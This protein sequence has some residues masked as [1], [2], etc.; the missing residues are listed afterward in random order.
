MRKNKDVKM[1][2]T[3]NSLSLKKPRLMHLELLRLLAIYLVIFNHT[4][5]AGYKLFET[6][7][8]SPL[9]FAYMM[10]SVFCKIAV[11]LF[12]MISGALLLQ[13]EESY[14][15]LFKKRILRMVIVLLVISLPYYFW[16]QRAHGVSI[17]NFFTYIYGNSA[18]TSLWYLYSYIGFLLILPFL[19]KMVKSMQNK[20]FIY[21]FV[22]Y[23]IMVGILP[24]L[25]YCFFDGNIRV[26]EQFQPVLFMSQSVFFGLMGYYFE[27][28]FEPKTSKVK[29]GI[30]GVCAS[31]TVILVTCIITHFKLIVNCAGTVENSELFFNNFIAIPTVTMYYLIKQFAKRITNTKLQ[32]VIT[33]MGSAVFGVYLI[34]KFIR[35]FTYGIYAFSFPIVGSFMA[36]LLW[37]AAVWVI[38]LVIVIIVKNI[39]II[40]KV[41]NKFI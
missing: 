26:H 13:K 36:A 31:L 9:Y 1:L 10:A 22:G 6:R 40:K 20:D 18:S 28:V 16:L 21:L 4:G 24:T 23:I 38:G 39:P 11:P 14:R 35:S 5:N 17:L 3:N 25:E 8:D 19:R 30:I 2:E 41:V 29:I 33:L 7:V 34:E 15:E 32:F 27:Y 37:S 12:F